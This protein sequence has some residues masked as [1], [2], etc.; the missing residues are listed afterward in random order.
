[1]YLNIIKVIKNKFTANIILN[2]EILKNFLLKRGKKTSMSTLITTF[3][4]GAG[5][6]SHVN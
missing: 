5:S 6:P 4:Y 3:Q 1:M 2:G